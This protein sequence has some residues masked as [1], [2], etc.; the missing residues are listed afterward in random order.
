MTTPGTQSAAP[1]QLD[2]SAGKY[3]TSGCAKRLGC[4]RRSAHD[5]NP[6]NRPLWYAERLGSPR[7]AGPTTRQRGRLRP[8]LGRCHDSG[9]P[10]MRRRSAPC[11]C[12][13]LPARRRSK[14]RQGHAPC[15]A[16]P[17]ARI[18]APFRGSHRSLKCQSRGEL[19][20]ASKPESRR[21]VLRRR[22]LG[23]VRSKWF[24]RPRS[25]S[26]LPTLDLT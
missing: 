1:T 14:M 3:G 24:Q 8:V 11:Q 23:A 7:G 18:R 2:R 10:R 4:R 12:T 19:L 15:A 16:S 6:S 21:Y 9:G 20:R 25:G 17:S 26:A 5:A 13:V 22:I